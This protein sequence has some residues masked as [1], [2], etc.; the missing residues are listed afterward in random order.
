MRS[1]RNLLQPSLFLEWYIPG[2]IGVGLLCWIIA[3]ALILPVTID[4]VHT[5]L[6]YST[7]SFWD[8]VTYKDPVPNNHILNTLLIKG[9]RGV[10]GMTPFA[11]RLPNILGFVLFMYFSWRIFRNAN[12]AP[13]F[14]TLGL[15]ALV[16]NPYL[17]DFFSL[18]RGYALSI[19]LMMG[20]IT[21]ILTWLSEGR[22]RSLWL[23]A[24]FGALAV[25]AN[26]TVLNFYAAALVI[27]GAHVLVRARRQ[28]K[29]LSSVGKTLAPVLTVTV[30]LGLI[31]Y[32]PIKKMIET[33]Q[34]HFWGTDSFYSNTLIELVRSFMYGAGHFANA[35]HFL[36]Y[37][38]IAVSLGAL[39]VAAFR[40]F[41]KRPARDLLVTSLFL[42]LTV[43]INILQFLLFQ[44][45]YLNAR[46]ALFL[47]PLFAL[48]LVFLVA[49]LHRLR[50]FL[51]YLA[52]AAVLV[53]GAFH[54]TKTATMDGF[55][56][57]WFDANT[58]EILDI[59][60]DEF[61]ARGAETPLT[62]NTHWLYHNSFLFHKVVRKADWL[63]LT[64]FHNETDTASTTDFYYTTSD[65]L[66]LIEHR[67][68]RWRDFG[69]QGDR[70]LTK[71][72]VQN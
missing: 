48:V 35:E 40:I 6:H 17:I 8:I 65:E 9:S 69:W 18:A 13:L 20:S 26:F 33:D 43:G 67:Y 38:A 15:V 31:S 72:R 70:P 24:G 2:L 10:F 16:A 45:P 64:P 12:A 28:G 54:F 63:E 3:K 44:T 61:E 1:V 39:G 60:E 23:A 51:F 37:S 42:W 50:P 14:V 59:L 32:V 36:A 49:Q 25:Y 57:W 66:P 52:S 30:L 62:L 68:A 19:A 58:K 34:F 47:Y 11:V 56:E 21:F 5:V 41:A 71:R 7:M 27:L 53:G 29:S 55:R 46:T 22:A 4:E